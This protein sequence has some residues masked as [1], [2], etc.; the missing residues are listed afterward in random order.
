LIPRRGQPVDGSR[1][2]T[3]LPVAALGERE[4]CHRRHSNTCAWAFCVMERAVLA[5]DLTG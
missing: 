5:K 3:G 1:I 2:G 4:R